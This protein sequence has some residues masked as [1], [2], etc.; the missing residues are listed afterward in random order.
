[1]KFTGHERDLAS[2]NGP[3]DDLDYMHARHESP[4]TGRF[5]SND[6]AAAKPSNAQTWNRYG[7]ALNNPLK[8]VD[9]DGHNA[10][11]VVGG[12]IVA[13]AAT[14]A[15]MHVVEMQTN[16]SYRQRVVD[17]AK[18]S[19]ELMT[20]A[21]S[22]ILSKTTKRDKTERDYDIT[23][24][25]PTKDNKG[26]GRGRFQSYEDALDQAV[27]IVEKQ[28]KIRKGQAE[29]IIDSVEK[30]MDRL[31]NALKDIEVPADAEPKDEKKDEGSKKQK[32]G[33]SS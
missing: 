22:S 2:P 20:A 30:S 4:V 15:V 19:A 3:G 17:G 27:G 1:M 18:R 25:L 6:S 13:L 5:L 8:H 12:V 33:S 31:F 14:A 9:K 32:S 24:P 23:G 21:A 7:Y 16:P 26:G 10:V 28:A 11:L 29:G